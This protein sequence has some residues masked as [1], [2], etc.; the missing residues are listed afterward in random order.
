MLMQLPDTYRTVLYLFYWEEY[1]A[2]EIAKILGKP[3]GTILTQLKKGREL[4]KTIFNTN[5]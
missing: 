2:R 1:K 4:F 3:T 5:I